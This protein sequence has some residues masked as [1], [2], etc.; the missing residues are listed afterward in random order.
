MGEWHRRECSAL[1][2][3]FQ[4]DD[5]AWKFDP[6][7]TY[8]RRWCPELANLSNKIIHRPFDAPNDALAGAG[9]TLVRAYPRTIVDHAEAR[10]AALVNYDAV[11][12][13]DTHAA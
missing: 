3:D 11:R 6:N 9:V 5:A 10:R 12:N 2:P 13:T 1:I 4:S 7:G 8:I